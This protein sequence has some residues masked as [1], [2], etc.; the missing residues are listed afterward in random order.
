MDLEDVAALGE[1]LEEIPTAEFKRTIDKLQNYFT[2][3]RKSGGGDCEVTIPDAGRAGFLVI[4]KSREVRDRVL[5]RN[6][7]IVLNEGHVVRIKLCKVEHSPEKSSGA[8][9][10]RT[11]GQHDQSV[12][13]PANHQG[14]NT[15]LI[16]C[17]GIAD[18]ELEVIFEGILQHEVEFWTL[19]HNTK[20][21]ICQTPEEVNKILSRELIVAGK[22][23]CVEAWTESNFVDS[24]RIKLENLDENSALAMVEMFIELCS[25]R[26]RSEFDVEYARDGRSAIITFQQ[27]IEWKAFQKDC[28]SRK[29]CYQVILATPLL[30]TKWL[31]V[32]GFSSS[33]T[34]AVVQ[35]YFQKEVKNYGKL[36]TVLLKEEEQ[37]AYIQFDSYEAAKQVL[38]KQHFLQKS[39]LQTY[40]YY[41]EDDI[42][43]RGQNKPD[44]QIPKEVPCSVDANILALIVNNPSYTKLT[45]DCF[46]S[47]CAQLQ[48]D[49]SSS[50]IVVKPNFRVET[51]ASLNLAQHWEVVVHEQFE[52]AMSNFVKKTFPTSHPEVWDRVKDEMAQLMNEARIIRFDRRVLKIH[53]LG[54][55]ND[56]DVVCEKVKK[57]VQKAHTDIQFEH[58]YLNR[59]IFLQLP[60]FELL[61][62]LKVDV[63]LKKDFPDVSF[64]FQDEK[65]CLSFKGMQKYF[66][67]VKD[68]LQQHLKTLTQKDIALTTKVT[69][70]VCKPEMQH[71]INAKFQENSITA[72]VAC[73]T[74][75]ILHSTKACLQKA[76]TFLKTE[77]VK[78]HFAIP[79]ESRTYTNG[80]LWT[81]FLKSLNHQSVGASHCCDIWPNYDSDGC[82]S[83]LDIV[84]F[85]SVVADANKQLEFFCEK[86][87]FV[88]TFFPFESLYSL[89]YLTDV[90]QIMKNQSCQGKNIKADFENVGFILSGHPKE[91]TKLKD[92]ISSHKVV[93]HK[94]SVD[95]PGAIKVAKE[96]EEE[97]EN[98]CKKHDCMG[99]IDD[100]NSTPHLDSKQRYRVDLPSSHTVSVSFGNLLYQPCDVIVNAANG[101]LRHIGG[102]AKAISDA[103]GPIV[104]KECDAHVQ[105]HGKLT[106]GEVFVSSSGRL[107]CKKIIHAVGPRWNSHSGKVAVGLLFHAVTNCLKE[108]DKGQYK[109]I[110]FPA[111]SGGI[112]AFPVKECSQTIVDAIVA[113]CEDVSHSQHA[114]KDIHIVDVNDKVVSALKDALQEKLGQ[115]PSA[116]GKATRHHPGIKLPSGVSITMVAGN[117]EDEMSDVI[118]NSVSGSM[119][120]NE[121]QLSNSILQ[122]AGPHLQALFDQAVSSFPMSAKQVIQT[123]APGDLKCKEVYHIPLQVWVK[124]RPI[125]GKALCDAVKTCLNLVEKS[126]LHSISFPALGTG[127]LN[128]PAHL[129]ATFMLRE[130]LRFC[131]EH[132]PTSITD[133][134]FVL[135]QQDD[136]E[137]KAFQEVM[138]SISQP[139]AP[140]IAGNMII[141]N[142]AVTIDVGDITTECTQSIICSPG[143]YRAVLSASG[144]P[145]QLF[146]QLQQSAVSVIPPGNLN[147]QHIILL[148]VQKNNVKMCTTNA[149]M[150]CHRRSITSVAFPALCTGG[151][152]LSPAQGAAAMADAFR[153][154]LQQN[155]ITSLSEIRI[156]LYMC[157]MY[158][159]FCEGFVG[160]Q[161]SIFKPFVQGWRKLNRFLTGASSGSGLSGMHVEIIQGDITKETTDAIVNSTSPTFDLQQGVSGAILQAA[162]ASVQLECQKH[163]QQSSLVTSSGNLTCNYIIHVLGQAQPAEISACVQEALQQCERLNIA[164]VSL[165]AIGTGAGSQQAAMA[166]DAMLEGIMQHTPNNL[167]HIR[168]VVFQPQMVAEFQDA[169]QKAMQTT[170]ANAKVKTKPMKTAG[171]AFP[172]IKLK[173]L[174]LII[175]GSEQRDIDRCVKEVQDFFTSSV[176]SEKV[177]MNGSLKEKDVKMLLAI[178]EDHQIKISQSSNYLVLEGTELD[179]KDAH[180]KLLNIITENQLQESTVVPPYWAEME[181]SHYKTFV[182]VPNSVEYNKVSQQFLQSVQSNCTIVKIERIQDTDSWERY[183]LRKKQVS[184][185]SSP[186]RRLYH[187][188]QKDSSDSIRAF[189]FDRNYAGKNAIQYGK[190]T[191]FA[192]KAAYSAQTRYSPPDTNGYRYIFQ[193]LVATGDF[194]QGNSGLVAPPPK[195]GS[196]PNVMYDS[197]V[198]NIQNPNIFVIFR[199]DQAYPEYLITFH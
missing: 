58:Q 192:V 71:A 27:P 73:S 19:K 83:S 193:A 159:D 99:K 124:N 31:C 20:L 153:E 107:A 157:E 120:L 88:E 197:V 2:I 76:E 123:P 119:Q 13:P 140:S 28:L 180:I 151:G 133:V 1:F 59:L 171:L 3:Q 51:I 194:C 94:M 48:F 11:P 139:G 187:G 26:G 122:K 90:K 109:S 77:I 96:K 21:L 160:K 147:C 145:A 155:P 144:H 93:L 183:L 102:L 174:R 105:K 43:I 136:R 16:T 64:E 79:K 35:L 196:E 23:L 108:A 61:Q 169:L 15:I 158:K 117:I 82:C 161:N 60:E 126:G 17:D 55:V 72:L 190:G 110:V 165:P 5:K 52:K 8:A 184:S 91:V 39:T 32:E 182:L 49:Q 185:V 114:L 175:I 128:Y 143:V 181:G 121:G 188:T 131:D 146:A 106:E 179:V 33:I 154:F 45:E 40:H 25:H 95:K 14:S 113:Y 50:S 85:S 178:Q 198:D 37:M 137:L 103:A 167:N 115:K 56:V 156:I 44:L 138:N 4:F 97:L 69:E 170:G 148:N 53:L 116:S 12:N 78:Q 18:T 36:N 129:T 80:K 199:D 10:S 38:A 173:P 163:G 104:Q 6:H 9:S 191:Y 24:C 42:V 22:K 141:G 172:A 195:G 86:Y 68:K 130:V 81:D 30:L 112:F 70:F 164:S 29:L 63:D 162:G 34:Q 127:H 7:E 66:D 84:A 189:G 87:A 118:V 46:R 75:V 177:K 101:E 57:A 47:I 142:L 125:S 135:H 168:I 54:E 67:D 62:M 92:F 74:K 98:L 166:A 149:L 132:I 41:K 186:E 111:I 89:K 152:G 100:P 150:E 134:R 65:K 176:K